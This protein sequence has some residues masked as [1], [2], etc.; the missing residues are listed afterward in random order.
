MQKFNKGNIK[1]NEKGEKQK[2]KKFVSILSGINSNK[3]NSS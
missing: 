2:V 1:N 3:N